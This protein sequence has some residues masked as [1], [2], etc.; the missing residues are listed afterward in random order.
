MNHLLQQ[1]L[2][3]LREQID[4]IDAELLALLSKRATLSVAIGKIKKREPLPVFCR[5][6]REIDILKEMTKKNNGPLQNHQLEKVFQLI[7]SIS[8]QLQEKA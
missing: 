3:Q 4:T 2:L 8:C 1:E 5:P 6:E 7:F